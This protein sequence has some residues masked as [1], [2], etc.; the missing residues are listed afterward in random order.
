ML[1]W[2]TCSEEN[3][4]RFIPKPVKCPGLLK[5]SSHHSVNNSVQG[6]TVIPKPLLAYWHR[7]TAAGSNV[8]LLFPLR[9]RMQKTQAS[10]MTKHPPKRKT[11]WLVM[12]LREQSF[13]AW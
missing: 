8:I 9:E 6:K 3:W 7:R 1:K 10:Q 5:I 11:A 2:S 13:T 4:W 12:K